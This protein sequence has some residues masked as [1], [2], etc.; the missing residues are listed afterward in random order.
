MMESVRDGAGPDWPSAVFRPRD[1]CILVESKVRSQRIVVDDVRVQNALKMCRA[2]H[3]HVVQAFAPDR[4]NH[5][6]YK[7]I[8]PT[9]SRRDRMVTNTHRANT[10]SRIRTAGAVSQGNAPVICCANHFAVGCPVTAIQTISW[11]ASFRT[12]VAY[13]RSKAIVGTT[14]RSIAAAPAR[15]F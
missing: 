14:N 3:D 7:A 4:T 9:R 12:T 10:L 15:W 5:A 8:L 1:W 11:R 6:H 2:E 13:S